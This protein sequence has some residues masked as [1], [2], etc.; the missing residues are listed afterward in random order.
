M[1]EMRTAIEARRF[2]A[3]AAEFHAGYTNDMA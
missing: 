1:R 2:A 3:W